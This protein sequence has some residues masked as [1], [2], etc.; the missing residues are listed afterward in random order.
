MSF[1]GISVS[2]NYNFMAQLL[3][4][5]SHISILL[6]CSSTQQT[7]S[8]QGT[9][10]LGDANNGPCII[11]SKYTQSSLCAFTQEDLSICKLPIEVIDLCT[12]IE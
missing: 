12:E 3:E 2:R 11:T 5:D 10:N 1:S 4:T 6:R 9:S 7:R 8:R